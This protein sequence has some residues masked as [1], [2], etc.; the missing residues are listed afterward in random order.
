MG[1]GEARRPPTCCSTAQVASPRCIAPAAWL[2][3][4][5]H[6]AWRRAVLSAMA[7]T[8]EL[9]TASQGEWCDAC[10]PSAPL[11]PQVD[12]TS[13]QQSPQRVPMPH[14]GSPPQV[15]HPAWAWPSS[16]SSRPMQAGPAV[17]ASPPQMRPGAGLRRAPP[18]DQ[19]A[20]GSGGP[21]EPA[22]TAE[23][24]S[25]GWGHY[26][27]NGPWATWLAAME[28][29]RRQQQVTQHGMPEWQP[30]HIACCLQQPCLLH[31]L[32]QLCWQRGL[33]WVQAPHLC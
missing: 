14:M 3:A 29:A 31:C 22:C 13:Q 33:P 12:A 9:P 15:W 19:P 25:P 26:G 28:D 32:P 8:H 6:M 18:R 30:S 7:A 2:P 5:A 11:R 4:V 23:H 27:P 24:G 16:S 17:A 20:P 21:T 10:R 1:R